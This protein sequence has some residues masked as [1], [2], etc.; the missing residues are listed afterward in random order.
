MTKA[1]KLRA[2]YLYVRDHGAYW[3]IAK[4]I[5]NNFSEKSKEKQEILSFQAR[6]QKQLTKLNSINKKQSSTDEPINANN[7]ETSEDQDNDIE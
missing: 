3:V 2:A 6:I 1:Q 5:S 7:Y 4:S